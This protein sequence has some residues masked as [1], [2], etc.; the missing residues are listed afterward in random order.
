MLSPR[1]RDALAIAAAAALIPL[2]WKLRL[3]DPADRVLIYSR[4]AYQQIYPMWMRAAESMRAGE[5][6][7]WN[8]YQLG[9]IPFHAAV[10]YGIFYPLNFLRLVMPTAAA[11]EATLVLHLFA[12][13]IFTFLYARS[14]GLRGIPAYCSATAF[15]LAGNTVINALWFL[16]A[17]GAL[18]WIPL[19]LFGVEK[20]VSEGRACWVAVL[21]IAVAM[22]ILA[23]WLQDWLHLMH[24]VGFYAAVRLGAT[25][26]RRDSRAAAPRVAILLALAVVLGLGLAAVQ[27]VPSMELQSLGWR[28]PGGL[29]LEQTLPG[30]APLLQ[31]WL[32]EAASSEPAYPRYG[33]AG[34]ATIVLLP[35]SL[36]A[37]TRRSQVVGLW[38][39]GAW[40]F[41]VALTVATPV[42]H[43]YRALPGGTWFREPWRIIVLP[44]FAAAMLSGVALD[45]AARSRRLA[46]ALAA[47]LATALAGVWMY[48]SGLP[49]RTQ[50]LLAASLAL[51]WPGVL[52]SPRWR[53]LPLAALAVLLGADLFLS[54]WATAQRPY[55]NL[56][57]L[58]GEAPLLE[59]VRQHQGLARTYLYHPWPFDPDIMAKQ[60]TLRGIYMVGDYE[61]L[62]LERQ[63]RYYNAIETGNGNAP[64]SGFIG[65]LRMH[66]PNA[67][68]ERLLSLLGVRYV[69]SPKWASG[70]AV[71]ASEFG[72]RDLFVPVQ[73]QY[74]IYENPHAL[75]RAYLAYNR[76]VVEDG[77]RAIRILLRASFKPW[78]TVVV[79]RQADHPLDT[80]TR[81]PSIA[82]VQPEVYE[83][84][85]V[86]VEATAEGDGLL[87]LTD[88]YYPG[89][90][91]YVDG[92]ES[93]IYRANYL[94]R[95]VRLP[96][97]HHRVEFRFEPTSFRAGFAVSLA[98][99]LVTATLL[100][101]GARRGR[102]Q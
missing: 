51:L 47:M 3:S 53:R 37:A 50:V 56:A 94:F 28:R 68:G 64:A 75:P 46:G 9:G 30:G 61:I 44:S 93:P 34:I 16:P 27:L 33:Y 21:G 80:V 66:V 24:A 95:A 29:T 43:L 83:A 12:A 48:E 69:L 91:A 18:V 5:I 52:L 59:F 97:G 74:A 45:F 101:R 38:V 55:Q 84:S 99:L 87:V 7:L 81:A 79:E 89:W 57:A 72:W 1:A 63:A 2:F 4:D 49:G 32:A 70:Y 35:L 71:L 11:M 36:A 15:A 73:S 8:P 102:V 31:K 13:W 26:L 67:V 22:P 92:V 98:T 10:L 39:V 23:G 76:A 41:L 90:K 25:A 6:P 96:P 14:I 77:E 58:D 42:F 86:V 40:G 88:T 78:L 17:I 20:I 100:V 85:H 54:A 62:S 19:A 60:G 65:L 82:P